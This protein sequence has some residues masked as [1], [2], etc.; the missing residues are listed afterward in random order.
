[1]VSFLT[2]GGRVQGFA[3]HLD[4]TEVFVIQLYGQKKWSV[5]ETIIPRPSA[6]YALDPQTLRLMQNWFFAE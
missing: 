3:P 4:S 2:P 6:G 5:W 1:M